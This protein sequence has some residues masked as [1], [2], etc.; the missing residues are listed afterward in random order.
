MKNIFVS[1]VITT[2]VAAL[3]ALAEDQPM[4]PAKAESAAAPAPKPAPDPLH[5]EDLT[6]E[7]MQRYHQ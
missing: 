4:K 3:P 5:R 2:L 6:L 7:E 1:A